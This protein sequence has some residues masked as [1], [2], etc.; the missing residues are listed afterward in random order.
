MSAQADRH[1]VIKALGEAWHHQWKAVGAIFHL[2]RS[3]ASQ[4]AS[5]E[6]I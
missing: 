1:L 2:L 3:N 4:V 6:A 5:I